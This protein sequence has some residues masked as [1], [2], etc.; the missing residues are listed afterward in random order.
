MK[1]PL[2][3]STTK[4]DEGAKTMALCMHEA[5]GRGTAQKMH[6]ANYAGCHLKDRRKTCPATSG[7]FSAAT[8]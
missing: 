4:S 1:H 5:T 7:A 3:A 6:L 2:L 8:N